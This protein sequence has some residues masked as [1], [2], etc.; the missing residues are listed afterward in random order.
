ML[1]G[2]AGIIGPGF[3]VLAFMPQDEARQ[4]TLQTLDSL[5]SFGAAPLLVDTEAHAR[6]PTLVAPRTGHPA[7]DA[8]AALHA[9]YRLA[10]V[11]ARRRGRD[12]DAP[13]HLSK[14]TQTV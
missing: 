1:H 12:P 7:L 2:P 5:A 14:I 8:I 11:L 13:L 9:F 4:G 10:E 3:P 6:W